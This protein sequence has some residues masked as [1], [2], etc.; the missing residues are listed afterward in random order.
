MIILSSTVD[1]VLGRRIHDS[2]SL[3]QRKLFL[4]ISLAVNLGLLGVFKYFN[5]FVGSLI[6]SFSL[7][8]IQLDPIS[9]NIILPVGISFYT[10]QTLSYTIDIYRNRLKPTDNSLHFFAFVS[11]FPQLVAGP[12]ERARDLLPQFEIKRSFDL[13]ST[14]K[15]LRQILWGLFKKVVIADGCAVYVNLIFDAP[16]SYS[17]ILLILGAVLFSIQIYCDFSGY[18]DIAIGLAKLLG[19]KLTK[20]FDFPFFSTSIT[21]MWRRWHITLSTWTGE[22]I[23][24]PLTHKWKKMGRRGITLALIATFLILGIW[25]GANWTFVAFGLFHGAIVASEYLLRRS[26][27]RK[28]QILK[29]TYL[30]SI[31]GWMTT[32]ALWLVGMIL[33]RAESID[34]AFSYL[35]HI[36]TQPIWDGA[37]PFIMGC[38][39]VLFFALVMLVFEW[40]NRKEDF[41]LA[42][43]KWKGTWILRWS[44]YYTLIFAMLRYAGHQQD[45]I[46]FQF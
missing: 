5:F 26:L 24:L 31:T 14:K 34:K 43:G 45:F 33:F 42:I 46:Y 27:R 15:G 21:E 37:L 23:F 2:T 1:F 8:G 7:I 6:D 28:D 36:F 4:Y 40:I 19:F 35:T 17:S 39:V 16:D 30:I 44:V 38:K 10:F 13:E 9:L 29:N 25:H 20:N 18:S 3:S 32:M 22:Y 41:G 11:F 12:I